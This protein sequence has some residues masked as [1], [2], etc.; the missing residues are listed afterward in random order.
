MP[1]T[2]AK[3]AEPFLRGLFI[4]F[5]FMKPFLQLFRFHLFLAKNKQGHALG[6][7]ARIPKCDR[8]KSFTQTNFL[9]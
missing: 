2:L 3:Q 7:W 5:C 6:E 9:S 1:P 4:S 8:E